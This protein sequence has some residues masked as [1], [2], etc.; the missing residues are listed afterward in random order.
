MPSKNRK[1]PTE[2]EERKKRSEESSGEKSSGEKSNLL[3][4]LNETTNENVP[5]ALKTRQVCALYHVDTCTAPHAVS[6]VLYLSYSHNQNTKN[7][8]LIFY[9]NLTNLGPM[10]ASG[11]CK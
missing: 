1:N 9:I 4:D 6:V 5:F 11:A 3:E 7:I 8:C 10:K 2:E